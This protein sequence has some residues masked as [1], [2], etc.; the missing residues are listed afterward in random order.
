M[1]LQHHSLQRS[2]RSKHRIVSRS[3]ELSM[4]STSFLPTRTA[5]HPD[6]RSAHPYSVSSPYIYKPS[7]LKVPSI[8]PQTDPSETA[9]PNPDEILPDRRPTHSESCPPERKPTHQMACSAHPKTSLPARHLIGQCSRCS[10]A[11]FRLFSRLRL[12]ASIGHASCGLSTAVPVLQPVHH[13]PSTHRTGS[14]VYNPS[15]SDFTGLEASKLK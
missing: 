15:R 8:Q 12:L 7:S 6:R 13:A 5:S 3:G 11:C 14:Y 2:G 9:P 10:M 4:Q 1:L